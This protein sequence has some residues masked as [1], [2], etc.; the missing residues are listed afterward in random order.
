MG[1]DSTYDLYKKQKS[2]LLK[3]VRRSAEFLVLKLLQY[4]SAMLSIPAN[5]RVGAFLGQVA[6][7]L[8]RKDRG[9]A[10]YQLGFCYPEMDRSQHLR[11][12]RHTFR[13]F[14]T[15]LFETLAV[16]RI[17]K[18]PHRWIVLE[19]EGLIHECLKEGKGLVLMFG[20]VGNWELYA[21]IYEMLGIR[22][23]TISSSIGDDK[24]DRLLLSIR[25]SDHIKTIHRGDR[26]SAKEILK[27]FRNN[28][29]FLFAMDQDTR[30]KTV[31]VNF[32][33]R[34]AA[35]ASG[36]ATFAQKFD[37][38]VVSGFGARQ[39]DGTHLYRFKLLSRSPYQGSEEEVIQLTQL[40][41]D[42]LETHIRHFPEQ[43][44]WF[45]RRWKNQPDP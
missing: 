3:P 21:I 33:G 44:V 12:A 34:K 11:I 35:T 41:N 32:F 29:V 1:R 40:Y 30:V 38:P 42:A 37:A 9:V 16:N 15:T 36:A 7:H 17:R 28:Q 25:H 22:G 19:N 2:S 24:L 13:H 8:A 4:L 45:H 39:P 23:M 27:C 43:W 14:G 18:D 10:A 5:Q 6:Y 31:Y 20:H 26:S